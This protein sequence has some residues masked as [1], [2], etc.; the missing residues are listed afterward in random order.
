MKPWYISKLPFLALGALVLLSMTFSGCLSSGGGSVVVASW[1]G[2]YDFVWY[3][4]SGTMTLTQNNGT[5]TGE[6][7]YV[8]GTTIDGTLTG[9]AVGRTLEGTWAESDDYGWSDSGFFSF[10]LLEDGSG[11]VGTWSYVEGAPG[12]YWN[13]TRR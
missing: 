13:G 12:Q 5:V 7:T 10:E 8:D 4:L 11:F 1:A 2:E 3:G 9:E 6:Y